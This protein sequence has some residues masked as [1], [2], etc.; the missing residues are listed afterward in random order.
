[1]LFFGITS[2]AQTFDFSC[3]PPPELEV[4]ISTKVNGADNVEVTGDAIT[5][6]GEYT[7]VYNLPDNLEVI[8]TFYGDTN[9]SKIYKG[10][11]IKALPFNMDATFISYTVKIDEDFEWDKESIKTQYSHKL[12]IGVVEVSDQD[13]DI[14]ITYIQ[15]HGQPNLTDVVTISESPINS[16]IKLSQVNL[17]GGLEFIEQDAIEGDNL[18]VTGIS[19]NVSVNGSVA[20]TAIVISPSFKASGNATS[21]EVDLSSYIT[22]LEN[23]IILGVELEG[24]TITSSHT[25][26]SDNDG[27]VFTLKF[28]VPEGYTI[29]E[30]V[31]TKT[32]FSEDEFT[33]WTVGD[34]GEGYSDFTI[35]VTPPATVDY[36]DSETEFSIDLSDYITKDGPV[37]HDQLLNG[38]VVA[39]IGEGGSE[40]VSLVLSVDAVEGNSITFN[41]VSYENWGDGDSWDVG[42]VTLYAEEDYSWSVSFNEVTKSNSYTW[43]EN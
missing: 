8:K 30:G 3:A 10:V 34:I 4:I 12:Y 11:Y 41:G 16:L 36:T 2:Q 31:Y 1:M 25:L 23:N 28:D 22:P 13:T 33:I 26:M 9:F 32:V 6:T 35:N 38:V 24:L 17:T 20:T 27:E 7:F 43:S 37:I 19:Y 40:K 42:E 21:I 14:N 18:G 29:T 15:G 39:Q 5:A